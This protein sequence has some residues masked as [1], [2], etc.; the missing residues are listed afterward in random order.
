MRLVLRVSCYLLLVT[1]YLLPVAPALAQPATPTPHTPA[2]GSQPGET[3]D[4]CGGCVGE[5]LP[6]DYDKC[7]ACITKDDHTWTVLGCL[8]TSPGGFTQ[9]A[10]QV[11]TSVVGGVAF[12]ALL[13][14]GALILTSS[15]NAER[16]AAGKSILASAI[17][18]LILVVFAVFILRFIG[19]EIFALPGF[20]G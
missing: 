20:G 12:L 6:P 2:P 13:Y 8:P 1:C 10:L 9:A 4:L 16:L 11:L 15:G 18:G 17:G 3:C 19:V 5:E 7:M 14:G